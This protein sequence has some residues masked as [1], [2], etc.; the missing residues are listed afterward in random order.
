[1]IRKKA[2]ECLSPRRH[3]EL[4]DFTE[5]D[6]NHCNQTYCKVLFAK[7]RDKVKSNPELHDEFFGKRKLV[8]KRVSQFNLPAPK[9]LVTLCRR[10]E[11]T[12]TFILRPYTEPGVRKVWGIT[13]EESLVMADLLSFMHRLHRAERR[14][15]SKQMFTFRKRTLDQLENPDSHLHFSTLVKFFNACGYQ[16][17][18]RIEDVQPQDV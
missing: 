8:R 15:D 13:F 10:L 9:E 3:T 18:M 11:C 1:M 5:I 7:M 14:I 2:H 6:V 12:L 17:S 4:N 16:I